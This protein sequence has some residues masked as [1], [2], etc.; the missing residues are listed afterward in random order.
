[1]SKFSLRNM[2]GAMWAATSL[3]N[4]VC[5]SAV[6]LAARLS[7]DAKVYGPNDSNFASV[8][9]RWSTYS[10]PGFA[11]SVE[12]ATEQD[13]AETVKFANENNTPYLAVN[14][15]HGAII[16]VGK[17]QEGIQ[18]HMRGLNSVKIADDGK[19]ADFG[20]GILAK[21]VIDGLWAKNK[22]TVTG[23]CHCVSLAGPG[24]GG[25]HGMLQGR[26]GL[27]SDNFVSLKL[28]TADGTITKVDKDHELWWAMQGAGHNFGIVTSITS[29]IYDT[30]RPLWA[31]ASFIFTGDKV[32]E[33]YTNINEKLL[34]DGNQE[35]DIINYSYFTMDPTVDP[36]NP[37]IMFFILQENAV[38]VDEKF[39]A[40]FTALGPA[41]SAAG[42]GDYRDLSVWTGNAENQTFCQKLGFAAMRYPVELQVYNVPAMRE[43]YDTFT[44]GLQSTPALG[45]SVVLFEGYSTQ[46]VHA[47]PA[48]STAYP[49]RESN[50]LVSPVMLFQEDT[51]ELAETANALGTQLREIIHKA[52]GE[53]NLRVYVNYA[54]GNEGPEAWYGAEQWRQDKLK[55]LK[56]K[57]DPEGKFSFFAPIA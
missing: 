54:L 29:K 53:P 19:T 22:Q 2:A 9:A 44:A 6:E 11:F 37:V 32:E 7:P 13:V 27:I 48:P 21:E 14:N 25:G 51:P 52:S 47:V 36:V 15:G 3:A 23:N 1:M 56:S 40:P 35:V 55:T 18:I 26:H 31:Y 39:T 8:T 17:M 12:V 43:T 28:V 42:A 45:F 5:G 46:G 16:T 30:N 34:K 20:G 24:L 41:T 10:A 33:L 57:Y 49:F 50:L 38:L 4:A